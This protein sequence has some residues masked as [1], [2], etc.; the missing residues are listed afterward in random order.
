MP[1]AKRAGAHVSAPVRGGGLG[2]LPH[3][4]FCFTCSEIDS[5]AI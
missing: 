5:N 2:V 4:F 1:L 3:N